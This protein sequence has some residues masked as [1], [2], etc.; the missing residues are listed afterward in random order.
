VGGKSNLKHLFQN[1]TYTELTKI[2]GSDLLQRVIPP[3]SER[4]YLESHFLKKQMLQLARSPKESGTM[5]VAKSAE[6]ER[7]NPPFPPQV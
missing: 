6:K 5:T 1:K 2:M 4:Y 3:V 7:V